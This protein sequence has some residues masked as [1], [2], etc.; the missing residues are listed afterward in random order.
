MDLDLSMPVESHSGAQETF[1]Q[2]PQT[3]TGPLWGEN[4]WIFFQNCAFWCNLYFWATAGPPKYRGTQG[5]LSPY[6]YLCRRAWI[7]IL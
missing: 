4:V 1:S 3:F 6:P 7:W 5:N 2:G